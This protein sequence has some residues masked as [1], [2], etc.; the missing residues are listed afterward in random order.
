MLSFSKQTGK[1]KVQVRLPGV[2]GSRSKSGFSTKAAAREWGAK[3]E[4][5]WKAELAGDL[6]ALDTLPTLGEVFAKFATEVCPGR[7][8]ERWEVIRLTAFQKSGKG[9]LHEGMPT[10]KPINRVTTDDLKVWREKRERAVKGSSIR[11]E[12]A[13]LSAVFRECR[14][15]WKFIKESP[16]TDLERPPKSKPRHVVYQGDELARICDALGYRD[17][18]PV[19]TKYQETAILALLADETMMRNGEMLSIR[20]DQIFLNKRYIRL[21][22]TKNGDSRDVPLSQRAIFLITKMLETPGKYAEDG[23]H[24][25]FRI[26]PGVRDQYYRRARKKAGVIGKTFHDTRATALTKVAKKLQGEKGKAN[27]YDVL[28]LAKMSG[29][30]DPRSVMIYFREDPTELAKLLD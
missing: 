13:L 12:M 11:R 24:L 5:E 16:L 25:L 27:A 2:E 26:N 10:K 7:K 6:S 8:G 9:E 3:T 18:I 20:R 19:A 17:D 29:H 22:D 21:E 1:H 30:R 4:Q 23:G 28:T 14:V 15:E